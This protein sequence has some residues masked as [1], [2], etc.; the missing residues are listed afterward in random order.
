[1]DIDQ[2]R[3]QAAEKAEVMGKIFD[4]IDLGMGNSV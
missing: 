3:S 1:M 2:K 4:L